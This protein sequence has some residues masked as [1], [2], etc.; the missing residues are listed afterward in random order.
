ML[1]VGDRKFDDRK[2]NDHA[3][4]DNI[5]ENTA[6]PSVRLRAKHLMIPIRRFRSP[7][8]AIDFD[9]PTM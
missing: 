2:F 9:N 7:I 4:D 5:G 3:F 1:S 8:A 6:I